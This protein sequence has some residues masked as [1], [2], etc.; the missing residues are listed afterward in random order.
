MASLKSLEPLPSDI[1]NLIFDHL[2]ALATDDKPLGF[3][4]IR[5]SKRAFKKTA[6]HLYSN[7]S[8][9]A[10]N[11][12]K[13]FYGLFDGRPRWGEPR[14][15]NDGH[16]EGKSPL[17]RRFAYLGL[18]RRVEIQ[19]KP[20]MDV[21]MTVMASVNL[22]KWAIG[23]GKRSDGRA[24]EP[25]L[26]WGLDP[27]F[28]PH[29]TLL[30]SPDA[31]LAISQSIDGGADDAFHGEFGHPTCLEAV[32][33]DF[34]DFSFGPAAFWSYLGSFKA[35][36]LSLHNYDIEEDS[37]E[38]SL[39]ERFRVEGI[40]AKDVTLVLKRTGAPTTWS[41]LYALLRASRKESFYAPPTRFVV[42]IEG[43]IPSPELSLEAARE[44]MT[45]ALR[46]MD[47]GETIGSQNEGTDV[48]FVL[49]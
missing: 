39:I 20:A 4:L 30:W 18:V 44:K 31:T 36:R 34:R 17:G 10:R 25:N 11:A 8:L 24:I 2:V 45:E 35:R 19:D 5:A 1:V 47:A 14:R 15:W 21:C 12:I 38:E 33:P 3:A 9:H 23:K 27:A 42:R 32:L 26:F 28:G 48:K 22:K 41:S 7:V 46:T 49:C 43:F 13:F 37:K 40:Q 16:F 6:P 29:G